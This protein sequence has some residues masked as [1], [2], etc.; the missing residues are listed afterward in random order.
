MSKI[1]LKQ[2]NHKDKPVIKL[3]FDYDLLLINAVKKI[4][5]CKWSNTMKCWYIPYREDYK[6]YLLKYLNENDFVKKLPK[7]QVLNV[8]PDKSAESLAYLKRFKTYLKNK[9]YSESTIQNY[10]LHI[11]HFLRY[12]HDKNPC[13]ITN[14]DIKDYIHDYIIIGKKSASF[15][16]VCVS[17]LKKFYEIV[18]NRQI[19]TAEFQRPKKGNYLPTVYNL[20]EIKKIL[21]VHTNVKH[22]MILSIIYSAGLR[23]GEVV[24]LKLADIDSKRNILWV[25]SGKG[26]KDRCTLL[27]VSIIPLLKA[28]YHSYKPKI[29]LFEYKEGQQYSTASIQ[30]IFKRAKIKAGINRPGGVH[31]LRHSFATHLLEQGT[32]LRYIQVL[33]GHKSSKTTEIYTH[34]ST[35][36]IGNIKSPF[37][38]LDL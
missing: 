38:N 29:W 27:P 16:S 33:L 5:D 19:N 36:D 34:V 12:F 8:H 10:L 32:D 25:R 23:L 17:A 30:K 13:T 35:R 4:P 14:D 22:K 11:K 3:V 24:N 2:S 18:E 9:R 31:T 6:A 37:D 26:N 20:T 7:K 21:T 1:K 15:Q 28:Y